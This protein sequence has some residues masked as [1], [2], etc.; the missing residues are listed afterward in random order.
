MNEGYGIDVGLRGLIGERLQWTVGMHRV[1]YGDDNDDTALVDRLP[2]LLHPHVRHGP[3][4]R[5]HRQGPGKC[6]DRIPLG[7]RQPLTAE[8]AYGR[9]TRM[10]DGVIVRTVLVANRG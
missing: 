10:N 4:R 2:V 6:I 8:R 9:L 5:Q 7:C 3:G 1:D